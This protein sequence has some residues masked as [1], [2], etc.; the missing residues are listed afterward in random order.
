MSGTERIERDSMGEVA[1]PADALWGAQTQRAIDNFSI[2]GRPLPAAFLRAL[3]RVKA[4]AARVNAELG[5]LDEVRASAIATAAE[6]VAGGAHAAAFPVDVYQTG[7][8]TSS[9]MNMNAMTIQSFSASISSRSLTPA[10]SMPS[11]S[12]STSGMEI[13]RMIISLSS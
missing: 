9:N 8:G 7:S 13:V 12:R 4:A 5:Q 1:V 6:T 3:A 2:G 11:R 10:K